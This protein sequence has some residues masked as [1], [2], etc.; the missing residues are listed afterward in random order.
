MSVFEKLKKK[1]TPKSLQSVHAA[2]SAPAP[3]AASNQAAIGG[4]NTN[5]GFLG[6]LRSRLGVG[7]AGAQQ[8]APQKSKIERANDWVE[9]KIAD[10]DKFIQDNTFGGKSKVFNTLLGAY[11]KVRNLQDDFHDWKGEMSEKYHNSAFG[12]KMDSAKAKIKGLFHS[13]GPGLMDKIKAK[14]EGSALQKGVNK[15]KGGLSSAGE[16]IKDKASAAGGWVKD[17]ASAAGNWIKSKF[18]SDKPGLMDKIKAK[19]Q[20]SALQ[21]GVNKVKGAA[22]SAGNWVKDKY[23]G[24]GLQKG[25][26]K[27]KSGIAAAGKWVKDTAVS[28]KDWVMDKKQRASD[29]IEDL[30]DQFADHDNERYEK[31]R[32]EKYGAE[33]LKQKAAYEAMLQNGEIGQNVS[34]LSDVD[35]LLGEDPAEEESGSLK[36]K[37]KGMI[38]DQLANRHD[39]VGKALKLASSGGSS[40]VEKLLPE[41]MSD[42]MKE[43]YG[44]SFSKAFKAI[45]AGVNVGIKTKEIH[46]LNKLDQDKVTA[47][48]K[49]ERQARKMSRGR[50]AMVAN[51]KR[52]RVNQVA[53]LISNTAQ[54]AGGFVD[55]FTGVPEGGAGSMVGK[56]VSG[57]AKA[58]GQMIQNKMRSNDDK[59]IAKNAVFGDKDTYKAIK[60]NFNLLRAKDMRLGMSHAT[61]SRNISDIAERS[62]YDMAKSI[63]AARGKGE[64][65]YEML[66]ARGYTDEAIQNMTDEGTAAELG[67]KQ[68]RRDMRR[69]M[70]RA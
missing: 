61:K 50:D 67:L 26:N 20:G 16:W 28:A 47:G 13:E 68:S 2:D 46:D 48:A 23:E 29:Y 53:K 64:G 10:A 3:A 9:G 62:R 34:E 6:R 59:N 32:A 18:H 41:D 37:A 51:L 57:V 24:S 5:P 12:K 1:S 60:G 52:D 35:G 4:G 22:A 31:H 8:Q 17:K 30:K 58:G 55:A 54:S 15:V 21:R 63:N 27:A 39:L 43:L 25:V 44:G 70:V 49:D 38:K 19:Y 11:D 45:N 36:D 7:G 14:Y 65:G 42:D 66:K 40:I 56:L 33:Y 69:R